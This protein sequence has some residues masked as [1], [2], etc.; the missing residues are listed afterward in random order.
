MKTIYQRTFFALLLLTALSGWCD[1]E[2]RFT[3]HPQAMVLKHPARMHSLIAGVEGQDGYDTDV[4][5]ESLFVSS[6]PAVATVDARGWVKPVANGKAAVT[7]RHGKHE[8]QVPVEVDL[9]QAAPKVSFREDVMPV[10]SKERAT[11]GPAT[12]IR[13][14]RTGS[15]FRC[16]GR[17]RRRI[18]RR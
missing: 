4:T 1:A 18:T 14:G 10:L 15:N 3:V 13:W 8:F 5:G 12:A 7:V 2:E 11:W 17:I 6:D 9:P 16:A